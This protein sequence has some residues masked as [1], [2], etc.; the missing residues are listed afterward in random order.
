VSAA[1]RV[2]TPQPQTFV[3]SR[4]CAACHT[5]EYLWWQ[6]TPHGHAYE[7]LRAEGSERDPACVGCH[8][9][10]FGEPHGATLE[11]PGELKGVGCES[12]HGPGGH[13]ADNPSDNRTDRARASTER[14][15]TVCHV[16]ARSP[17]FDFARARAALIVPAHGGATQSP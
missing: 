5:R 12:C 7:T 14:I 6:R 15:C 10:G 1:P 9:T 4:T 2:E 3:G 8:V 17:G 11:H 16:P 13:H